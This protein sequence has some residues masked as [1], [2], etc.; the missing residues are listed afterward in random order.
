MKTACTVV[1]EFGE[2]EHGVFRL[3]FILDFGVWNFF[4]FLHRWISSI[5]SKHHKF[6]F[7]SLRD[8][9]AQMLVFHLYYPPIKMKE[10][11][12]HCSLE[13]AV[14]LAGSL[15]L[16]PPWGERGGR[17]RPRTSLCVGSNRHPVKSRHLRGPLGWIA[18]SARGRSLPGHWACP[19]T[20][21]CGRCWK[22]AEKSPSCGQSCWVR[23]GQMTP[24]AT[25]GHSSR[26]PHGHPCPNEDTKSPASGRP[27]SS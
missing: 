26:T 16:E 20:R 1:P 21:A 13:A 14:Q 27:P 3:Y 9:S 15:L 19:L 7:C 18:A 12:T 22:R 11:G 5:P 17:F 2:S 4:F 8:P 25:L 23:K 10:T 6:L 24:S